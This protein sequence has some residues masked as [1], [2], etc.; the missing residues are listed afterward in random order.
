[1]KISGNIFFLYCVQGLSV[2]EPSARLYK[3]HIVTI[4]DISISTSTSLPLMAPAI[5][6]AMEELRR[7]Y[8]ETVDFVHTYLYDTKIKNAADLPNYSDFMV[9]DWYYRRKQPSNVTSFIIPGK[10]SFFFILLCFKHHKNATRNMGQSKEDTGSSQQPHHDAKSSNRI[11]YA[12]SSQTSVQSFP[13]L[14]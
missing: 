5:D 11:F 14:F 13:P 7:L 9:A 2:P 8:N 6:T 3:V 1:M 4:G 12:R 10:K